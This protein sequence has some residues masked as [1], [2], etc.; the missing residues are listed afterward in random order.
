MLKHNSYKATIALWFWRKRKSTSKSRSSP[1]KYK[2]RGKKYNYAQLVTP[3]ALTS[4]IPFKK[5]TMKPSIILRNGH[6]PR[7]PSLDANKS[8]KTFKIRKKRISSS[9]LSLTC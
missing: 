6:S 1:N 4:F 9:K 2:T 3:N 8:K 7:Q 5:I